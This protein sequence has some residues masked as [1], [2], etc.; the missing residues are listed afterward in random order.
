MEPR[1]VEYSFSTVARMFGVPFGL[2]M[3]VLFGVVGALL[4]G[5]LTIWSGPCV[6]IAAV[7]GFVALGGV[8]GTLSGLVFGPLM[9][10][11]VDRLVGRGTPPELAPGETLRARGPANLQVEWRSV[12]GWAYL[13]ERRLRFVPI[14]KGP[15]RS[16]SIVEVGTAESGRTF[17][18]LENRLQLWMTDGAI[19][20]L[21]VAD[22]AA[23]VAEI[24]AA[25]RSGGD[26]S[27]TG[28]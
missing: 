4:T 23:W 7:L 12:P 26:A 28:G 5:A 9:A 17:G 15:E 19:E 22:A 14:G 3:G 20:T 18:L 21:L 1:L 25:R 24:E 13:T 8:T 6:T 10:A 2:S 27:G 16:W 11:F